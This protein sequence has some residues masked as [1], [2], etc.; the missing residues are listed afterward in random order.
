MLTRS[1]SA[2]GSRPG[3][4]STTVT[5]VPSAA[6]AAELEADVTAADDE[7]GFGDVGQIERAGGIH[8]TRALDR[9][10]RNGRRPRS[11]GDDRGVKR[12][13]LARL[14]FAGHLHRARLETTRFPARR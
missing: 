2:P 6:Y 3:V 5:L 4:I 7:Q 14:A 9:Q 1:R 8:D 12:Q 10:A 11:C 13:R